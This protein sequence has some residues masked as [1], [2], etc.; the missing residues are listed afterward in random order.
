MLCD[1]IDCHEGVDCFTPISRKQRRVLIWW[2]SFRHAAGGL[3]PKT[4]IT[5]RLT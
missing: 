5:R 2:K 1:L 3:A 4:V